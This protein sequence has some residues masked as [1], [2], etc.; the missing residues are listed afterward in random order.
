M[1]IAPAH[2]TWWYGKSTST[3]V[4]Y[5][6]LCFALM[7]KLEDVVETVLKEFVILF[8]SIFPIIVPI[9]TFVFLPFTIL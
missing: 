8:F 7:R 3:Y 6:L 5:A 2:A 1:I 9:H 4:V